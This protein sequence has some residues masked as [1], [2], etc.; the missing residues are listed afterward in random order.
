MQKKILTD[1]LITSSA[2]KN[3]TVYWTL[4]RIKIWND[5]QFED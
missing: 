3:P 4:E 1:I 5:V 2:K